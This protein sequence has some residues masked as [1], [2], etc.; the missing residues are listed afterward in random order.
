MI[1]HCFLGEQKQGEADGSMVS[2]AQCM[3]EQASSSSVEEPGSFTCS[4]ALQAL[5]LT[6]T[7]LM[8]EDPHR[9]MC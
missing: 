4:A 3:E 7:K 8:K 2:L 1:A 6:E 5:M 9:D